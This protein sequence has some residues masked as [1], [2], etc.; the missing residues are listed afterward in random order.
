M[1]MNSQTLSLCM[2]V[3][4]EA[5]FLAGCLESAAGLVQ[6]IILVDT[7]ST[8]NTPE[9]GKV[10]A[11]RLFT[12]P[13]RNDFAMARNFSLE[14]ATMDWILVLDADE[15]IS[16][17]DHSALRDLLLG[18]LYMGYTLEQRT[19]GLDPGFVDWVGTAGD[20][21]EER[22]YPGYVRSHLLRLFRRDPRIRFEGRV[23]E[24]A[25]PSFSRHQL[26]YRMTSIPIHHYGK[27]R[28]KARVEHKARLYLEIGLQKAGT[29]PGNAKAHSELGAQ[30]LELN[31]LEKAMECFRQAAALAP[32]NH[33]IHVNIGVIHL[34]KGEYE[35]AE[36]RLRHALS[37]APRNTDA[38]LNLAAVLLRMGRFPEAQASLERAI[39]LR[40]DFGLA[41]ATM[42]TVLLCKGMVEEAL[43]CLLKA[44]DLNP[45]DADACS[46]LAWASRRLGSNEQA[47]F[48]CR[49]ALSLR[50]GHR[51]AGRMEREILEEGRTE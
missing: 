45:G 32:G 5:D 28:E 19:Y 20:M 25:E 27:V 4:N 6:E 38:L 11:A 10:F 47:L 35:E 43:P 30:F 29:D 23:H 8:D 50:P 26:P 49:K 41:H 36:K 33:D 2:I 51:N 48:W 37:L 1:A 39:E 12:F 44:V 15:V 21:E 34:R 46:N 40:P 18:D 17:K 7:G 24:L 16:P 22:G 13:W 9:V 31:D 3:K 42:G 14:H